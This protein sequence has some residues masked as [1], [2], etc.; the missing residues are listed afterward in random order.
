MKYLLLLVYTYVNMT[1]ANCYFSSQM[2]GDQYVSSEDIVTRE[3]L[4]FKT[5][6]NFEIIIGTAVD[7]SSSVKLNKISKMFNNVYCTAG[8]NPGN[9]NDLTNGCDEEFF[10]LLESHLLS[11]SDKI[12]AIG[13]CGLNYENVRHSKNFQ[14]TMLRKQIEL[15]MRY[16][17][18]LFLC[19]K[20]AFF[21]MNCI[22]TEYDLKGMWKIN[23]V[24][25]SFNGTPDQ[26]QIYLNLGFYIGINGLICDDKNNSNLRNA[27]CVIPLEKIIIGSSAPF[28]MP[29]NY[30]QRINV[31]SNISYI[32]LKLS[33]IYK[34]EYEHVLK[35]TNENTKRLFNIEYVPENLEVNTQSYNMCCENIKK[36]REIRTTELKQIQNEEIINNTTSAS[37]VQVPSPK[38]PA[39]YT[40]K[41]KQP[42]VKAIFKA[43]KNK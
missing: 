39:K 8:Y 35:I 19:E 10:S 43:E 20:N 17:K 9:L 13:E 31:P 14:I 30:Q 23:K 36:I 6:P 34:Q 32:I 26:A 11:Q 21:D 3:I 38:I 22:L 15:A 33:R 5:K 40:K 29:C 2:F 28:V 25:N 16:R 18:V 4:R 7:F 41:N 37:P 12:V 1:D 27:L 42:N 24:I